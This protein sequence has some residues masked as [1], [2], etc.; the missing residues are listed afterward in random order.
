MAALPVL[1]LHKRRSRLCVNCG[2]HGRRRCLQRADGVSGLRQDAMMRLECARQSLAQVA[3]EV[4]SVGHLDRL[5]RSC[6]AVLKE[7][8][9]TVCCT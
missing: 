4:P 2:R 7:E 3:Q 6:R 9:A 5:R 1:A 8:T